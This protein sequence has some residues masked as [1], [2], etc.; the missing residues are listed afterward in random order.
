M[1][2]SSFPHL[3]INC[4]GPIIGALFNATFNSF[5]V[6][7]FGGLPWDFRFFERIFL[8]WCPIT[9]LHK[10]LE[11]NHNKFTISTKPKLKTVNCHSQIEYAIIF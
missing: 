3:R 2:Y 4:F 6:L 11:N 5:V 8:F 9:K 7:G 1:Q 10:M